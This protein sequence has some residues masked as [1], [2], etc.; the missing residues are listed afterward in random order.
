[1]ASSRL[2]SRIHVYRR[3]KPVGQQRFETAI[4]AP[5]TED[6]GI[7]QEALDKGLVVSFQADRLACPAACDQA[8]EHFP[9]RGS[10][11]DVVPEKNFHRPERW[12]SGLMRIDA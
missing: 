10:A 9:R 7:V 2:L 8:V 4:V 5:F 11:V 6:G 12:M 3:H 1:M